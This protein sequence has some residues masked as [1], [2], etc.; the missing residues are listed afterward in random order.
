MEIGTRLKNIRKFLG[1][2]QLQFSGGVITESFYSRVENG[3][4][5]I[6]MAKLIKLLNYNHISL[7]EFF[8]PLFQSD[9]TIKVFGAFIDK[10]IERLQRYKRMNKQEEILINLLLK[11]VGG[12]KGPTIYSYHKDLLKDYLIA[13]NSIEKSIFAWCLL[14]YLCEMS[15]LSKVVD[16]TIINLSGI[17]DE[18]S[19]RVVINT[20]LTCLERF[21]EAQLPVKARIIIKLVD[22]I[23]NDS[24]FLL[25]KLITKYYL[26][27][28][29]KNEQGSSRYC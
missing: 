29:N 26:N 27:L 13:D 12:E 9:S 25:E 6:S 3:K 22:T 21:Y 23:S 17:K 14:S 1:L 2:T 16:K 20:L 5:D 18:F 15:E 10:D 24:N 4:S 7:A 8:E 11:I 28:L 19:L